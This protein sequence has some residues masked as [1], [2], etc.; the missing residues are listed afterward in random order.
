MDQTLI[1]LCALLINAALAGPKA[2]YAPLGLHRL[3]LLPARALRHFERKLNRE[4]RSPED[5]EMRGWFLVGLV[6]LAGIVIGIIAHLLLHRNLRFFE[7]LLVAACLPVRPVWD[8]LDA[9]RAALSEGNLAEAR[10]H[11]AGTLWK[12]HAMLDEPGV[13][14]AA[15]ETAAVDF[16]EKIVAPALAYVLIGLP[17]LVIV[18]C[19]TLSRDVLA[20]A[21][22]F[23]KA[24]RLTHD[25]LHYIPARVA[26]LL[27]I[28]APLFLPSG[29][30]RAAAMLIFPGLV[31]DAPRAFNL[32]A[33]AA[34]TKAGLGGPGS[35]YLQHWTHTGNPKPLPAEVRRAQAAYVFLNLFLFVF[36]GVFF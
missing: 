9:I 7:L 32:R 24:S 4:H 25:V 12:H 29:N 26:G 28:A 31:G 23:G 5:R 22:D 19:L 3:L 33:A 2:W 18:K 1:V 27:W 11:L 13:A 6:V 34:V 8:R 17:G 35:P 16:S 36:I 10:L 14:R 20:H 21:P 30:I 15:I